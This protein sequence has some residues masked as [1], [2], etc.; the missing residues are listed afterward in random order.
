M[1]YIYF[2]SLRRHSGI[3]HIITTRN[4]NEP[5]D[6]SLA[7]HTGEAV[8]DI[9]SNRDKIRD[10]FGENTR[11]VS[12]LQVHGDDVHVLELAKDIGWTRLDLS[13]QADALVTN[14]PNM[15]LT[16]LTADCVPILLYDPIR[17]AIGAAH[18]GWQGS[19]KHIVQKVVEKMM[20]LYGSDPSDI[21]AGIGPSIGG[22][23]Y[24]VGYD[25]AKHFVGYGNTVAPKDNGKYLLD[26]KRVN[27]MQLLDAGLKEENIEISPMCTS[28]DNEYFFS[29]R[30]EGG[31]KGRFMSI[32]ELLA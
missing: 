25:V 9:R 19:Q 5:A 16:I 11:F 22:C 17:N 28:C 7:L 24:E 15:A 4:K 10:F 1:E 14:E 27:A 3:R 20:G 12:P 23:C 30:K 2:E 13:L 26:L 8:D 29:Y 6:F 21:V 18:A 32:I 31:T